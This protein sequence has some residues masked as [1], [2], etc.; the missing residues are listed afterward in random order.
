MRYTNKQKAKQVTALISN[1]KSAE[2]HVTLKKLTYVSYK[3]YLR[4]CT[5]VF[6][7]QKNQVW[8]L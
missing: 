7:K 4:C 5:Q 1:I 3:V 8:P 2:A 6:S